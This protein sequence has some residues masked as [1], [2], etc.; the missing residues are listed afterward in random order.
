MKILTT[1]CYTICIFCLVVAVV[2]AML[3][4]WTDFKLWWTWKVF[5]SAAVMMT[6]SLVTLSLLRFAQGKSIDPAT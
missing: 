2:L 1:I 6:A 4:I 5:A 3:T